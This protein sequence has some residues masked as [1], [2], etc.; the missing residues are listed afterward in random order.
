M[1]PSYGMF[2]NEEE[3]H[4]LWFN[5]DSLEYGIELI[6]YELIGKIMGLAIYNSVIL[7][8]AFPPFVYKKLKNPKLVLTLDDLRWLRPT[9][10]D[11][12]STL[13][14]MPAEEV[15][16]LCLTFEVSYTSPFGD[17]KLH[18]LKENGAEIDVTAEN[19]VEYVGLYV[20][21]V[22]N[23][24]VEKQFNSFRNGFKKLC[25]TT[26]MRIF[27]PQELELLVCGNPSFDFD[28]FEA[29]VAYEN[30]YTRESTAIEYFWEVVREYSELQ[31]RLLLK[32]ITSSDR[33]PIEGMAKLG[34][35]I[36]KNGD[37]CDRL[38]T[39]QTCYNYLLLPNYSSKEKLRKLL[40]IAV[41]NSEGF[42]LR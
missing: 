23:K 24:S 38:P 29:S 8:L 25:D 3:A 28:A 16:N 33:I 35:V 5:C 42:G 20:D 40:T 13:L 39:A 7:E 21:W 30:G 32:F 14:S 9:V 26:A 1:D 18:N 41:E 37:D 6:E 36:L 11:S 10:G 2:M 22:L 34:V 19:R 17:V 4:C 15:E 27:Q 12:L 31:K